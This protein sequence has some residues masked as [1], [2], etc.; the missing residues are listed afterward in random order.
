MASIHESERF[1]GREP[2]PR[3]A[4]APRHEPSPLRMAR[5]IEGEIIPRLLMAHRGEAPMPAAA[6]PEAG[7]AA[8]EPESLAQLTLDTEVYALL[9][10]VEGVLARGVPIETV[11]IDLLAPAARVLGDYWEQDVC[12]FVDVTMGLWRLQQVVHELGGRAPCP[13]ARTRADRRV[14][15]TVPPGDQHSFGLVMIEEF[16]RRAGWRT[17]SAPDAGLVELRAIVGRQWFEMIGLTVSNIDHVAG[18]PAIVGELRR[19]SR[20]PAV[21]IM[22]GGGFFNDHPE[23]A[24]A[25]GA[26]AT[27][28]D[29]RLAL[30]AAEQLVER[31]SR[32]AADAGGSR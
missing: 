2:P 9:A 5:L 3:E 18:L 28:A 8:A 25:S 11:F 21:A 12:D 16:F 31:R 1:P 10:H 23:L 4:R 15:F 13:S 19:A 6:R 22:V 29:G 14:L 27:A 17:W 20:N 30:V 24:A 26:D 32:P 7:I